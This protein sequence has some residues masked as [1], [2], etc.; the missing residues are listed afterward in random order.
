MEWPSTWYASP[1]FWNLT[2]VRVRDRGRVGLG[3]RVRR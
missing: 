3:V 1:I 2:W